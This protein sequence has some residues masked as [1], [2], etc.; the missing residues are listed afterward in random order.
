MVQQNVF[1]QN[2]L[3]P[4]ELNMLSIEPV[5][6]PFFYTYFFRE[7]VC[8][9]ACTI[10]HISKSYTF[11]P[12]S[13]DLV[14]VQGYSIILLVLMKIMRQNNKWLFCSGR[15]PPLQMRQNGQSMKAA[16]GKNMEYGEHC[17]QLCNLISSWN[18]SGQMLVDLL[19]IIIQNILLW[20]KIVVV[21]LVV[22]ITQAFLF[23]IY[24]EIPI[25]RQSL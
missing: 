20:T 13:D 7:Y 19:I 18:F 24:S 15:L 23:S 25:N 16:V 2:L 10:I 3:A 1:I 4:F 9:T 6:V 12:T 8:R 21:T 17:A 14:P 11:W 5:I 22:S